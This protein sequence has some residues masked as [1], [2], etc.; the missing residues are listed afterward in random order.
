MNIYIRHIS[1]IA[2][3]INSSFIYRCDNQGY[4][5]LHENNEHIVNQKGDS[6]PYGLKKLLKAYPEFLDSA[7][8][9]NL[10]WK[11]GTVMRW[12]DGISGKTHDEKLNNPDLEDMMSQ[13]YPVGDRWIPPPDV[14]FEP[15][16]IRY[17]PF[18]KKMYGS[19]ESEVRQ[20]LVTINWLPSICNCMVQVSKINKVA[21]KLKAVSDEIE[22]NLGKEY[23]RYLSSTGGTFNWRNIAGTSRL[24]TH[25]FGTAI[26]INTKYS[27][28]WKWENDMTWKNQIPMEIVR[29]FEKHGFIWGGKWYHYDTMHFEYRPELLTD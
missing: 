14:N 18:F 16:R 23:Y 9:N 17:E 26:D 21:D 6:V 2:I 3:F 1:V 28:Y 22:A 7:D 11:D 24:S 10:Y 20:N 8:A 19:T 13:E 12:D 27:N 15:G 5:K 25:A 29:I 4:F